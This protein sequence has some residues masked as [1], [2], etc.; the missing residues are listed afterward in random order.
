[1]MPI[2][3]EPTPISTSYPQR[4]TIHDL[5]N[6]FGVVASAKHVLERDPGRSQRIA[7][8]EAIEDA[9]IRGGE[10][11]TGLLS[12]SRGA[13]GRKSMDVNTRI[14]GLAS[15]IRALAG[16]SIEVDLELESPVSQVRLVPTDFDAAILELVANAGAADASTVVIRTRRIGSRIWILVA[17]DGRGMSRAK[18]EQAR[19]SVDAGRAHGTGLCRVQ[20][21]M[22]GAHGHFL[23]QSRPGAGT[24]ISL[25]LPTVLKLAAGEPGARNGRLPLTMKEKTDEEIRQPVAA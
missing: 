10:L 5:R 25:N 7:L 1:M 23:I 8:L 16:P 9:A 12:G 24:T 2:Q 11:T 15:M 18:L 21:F 4:G 6:L 17:D 3:I 13:G 22:R 20:Q 14:L 19:R